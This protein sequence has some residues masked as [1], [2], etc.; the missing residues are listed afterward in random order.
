M[1]VAGS[2][3]ENTLWHDAIRARKQASLQAL[4]E[5]R[6]LES[7]VAGVARGPKDADMKTLLAGGC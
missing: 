6:I 4:Q 5:T 2:F 1:Q 3:V 7:G